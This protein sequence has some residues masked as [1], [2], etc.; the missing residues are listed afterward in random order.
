MRLKRGTGTRHLLNQRIVYH[1][2]TFR[3]GPMVVPFYERK[4]KR[5]S[6]KLYRVADRLRSAVIY[7]Q[8]E[9]LKNMAS[10]CS[11]GSGVELGV[12]MVLFVQPHAL[13]FEKKK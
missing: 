8:P 13:T 12:K 1:P 2:P 11:Y 4:W 9:N 6:G 5:V 7:R 3:G 10:D